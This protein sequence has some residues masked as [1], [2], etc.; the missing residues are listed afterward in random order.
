MQEL[1]NLYQ[2]FMEQNAQAF[3]GRHFEVAYHALAAALHCAH[4]VQDGKL[5]SA[6]QKKAEDQGRWLDANAPDHRLSSRSARTRSGNSIFASLTGEAK[7]MLL[8][9]KVDE[10]AQSLRQFNEKTGAGGPTS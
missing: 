10:Q 8:G 7:V 9:L 2:Q 6:V 3:V 5:I 4:E 1:R